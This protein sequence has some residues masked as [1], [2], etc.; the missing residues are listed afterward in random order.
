[1]LCGPLA[2]ITLVAS[3]SVM[4]VPDPRPAHHVV[5][6]T[7]TLTGED[8]AAIDA[9]AQR[10][11]SNGAL[12]V[13]VV[14]S[15]DGANPRQWTTAYF[16]RLRVD[17]KD[18]N[19]GVVLMAAIQDRK[20]EI[21]VG[22]G[23]P[24]HVTSTTDAIMQDVVVAHFKKGDA[25]GALVQ[26][27]QRLTDDVVAGRQEGQAASSSSDDVFADERP[28]QLENPVTWGIGALGLFGLVL[29]GRA[30]S[31]RRPR[32]CAK[33]KVRMSRLGEE[34]DDEH[35]HEGERTEERL[36][37]VD[38]DIWR[39]PQCN[40]VLKTR[41]GAFFTSYASCVSCRWKTMSS[42]S[43]TVSFA[44]TTSTGL[45]EVTERCGH[46]SHQRTYT[47]VIPMESSSSD[48]SSSSSSSDSG[49]GYSSGSGSS[50]SW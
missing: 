1:M 15:T 45:A 32:T 33:C 31:R 47:V 37:S 10:A 29:G 49:G 35:L 48:S 13:V 43:R 34:V 2:L 23:F 44:S 12:V 42:T 20:A 39:C 28:S 26:G 22:D 27:A 16:N 38:Y 6:L 8:I 41:W 7:G 21:V 46:C 18:R 19:R 25:R 24:G 4:D 11:A 17:T 5:D 3:T 40:Y 9:A 14:P 36:G 50:G 30:L